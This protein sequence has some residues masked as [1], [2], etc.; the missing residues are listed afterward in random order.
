VTAGAHGGEGSL[1]GVS[2]G[3]V[4]V[5][6]YTLDLDASGGTVLTIASSGRGG[7]PP[8]ALTST[9]SREPDRVRDHRDLAARA[10]AV[11]DKM[12]DATDNVDRAV[13]IVTAILK[14]QMLEGTVLADE[15]DSL[16]A[17]L[18][19]LVGTGRF[20]EAIR[21]ARPLCRL[22]AL[23]LRWAALVESLRL[24]LDAATAL[25]DMRT[26]ASA[27]HE[28]GTLRAAAGD[29]AG[30]RRDLKRARRIREQIGDQEGLMATD[31]NLELIA[32]RGPLT[33]RHVG[34]VAA[35]VVVATVLLL[36]LASGTADH[37]RHRTAR[38]PKHPPTRYALTVS[39]AGSGSGSVSLSGAS[40]AS[41]CSRSYL[42]GTRVTLNAVNAQGSAFTSWSGGCT[43]TS[44]GC[45]V[46]LSANASVTATFSLIASAAK[47]STITLTCPH[48]GPFGKSVVTTGTLTPPAQ[49]AVVTITYTPESTAT[50]TGASQ[51]ISGTGQA[52]ATG[53]SATQAPATESTTTQATTTGSTTT[54]PPVIDATVTHA[55]VTVSADGSFSDS[56][57]P[58]RTL[59]SV[60]ASWGGNAELLPSSGSCRLL[61]G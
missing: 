23:T 31:H 17:L 47:P 10:D 55:G 59:Y 41:S 15:I 36:E 38:S 26:Q 14:G 61:S 28:L 40:C 19:G 6:R 58:T 39:R 3:Q 24:M 44:P 21:L 29:R 57:T 42:A 30:A 60:R 50:T 5:G 48:A 18:R 34:I 22:F 33:L 12:S 13:E 1:A 56:F 7:L 35:A 46:T 53:S 2:T 43:G 25:A 4:P 20:A 11:I 54:P 49:S 32:A 27:L 9:L 16:L 37:A 52:P 8:E 45:T 51:S